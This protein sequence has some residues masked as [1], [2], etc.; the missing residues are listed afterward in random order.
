MSRFN[1]ER[2]YEERG[3]NDYKLRNIDDL[4]Y[5]YSIKMNQIEGYF[6]LDEQDRTLFNSFMINYFNIHGFSG[7]KI[8]ILKVCKINGD[9]KFEFIEGGEW[10]VRIIKLEL[11]N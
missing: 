6:K 1:L 3:L 8:S 9:V 2:A 7:K 10:K 11:M 5:I 4:F